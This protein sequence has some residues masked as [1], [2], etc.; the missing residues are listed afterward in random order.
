[1]K[2]G[3][4]N[5]LLDITVRDPADFSVQADEIT[6]CLAIRAN[7]VNPWVLPRLDFSLS[8]YS[9]KPQAIVVDFGSEPEYAEQIRQTCERHQAKLIYVNDKDT[10][11]LAKARNIAGRAVTT[12]FL[13]FSDLDYVYDSDFFGKIARTATQ[14]RM[15]KFTRRM[16]PMPIYHLGKSCTRHFEEL[17][18]TREKD[19]LLGDLSFA[20]I[21]TGFG[22]SFDFVAPYS[23][24]F[25]MHREFFDLSG[26]YCDDFRGHGS[27]DFEY[28]IRLAKL[29]TNLPMAGALE[30]DFYGPLKPSFFGSRD[31]LGFRRY[32]EMFTA[33]AEMLGLKTFHMWHDKPTG[34]NYWTAQNDWK[35]TRFNEILGKYQNSPKNILMADYHPRSKKAL[36]LFSDQKQWGYFLPLRLYG[37]GLEACTDLDNGEQT[38]ELLQRL[39][40]KKFDRICIFN[41][42]M[43]SHVKFRSV[44]EMAK[45]LG[46]PLT[47]IERGGL[48]GSLYY[49]DEVAYGDPDYKSVEDILATRQPVDLPGI[50]RFRD[51]LRLGATA[52]EQMEP[53]AD[54]EKKLIWQRYDSRKKVFIPLQLGDDMAVN[55]FVG[56]N[57]SYASF[58]AEIGPV[59]EKNPDVLFIVKRHPLNKKKSALELENIQFAEESAN[60][61]ALIDVADLVVTY[62]SGVGLLSIL[63]EKPT[64]NV[65]TSYYTG[66]AGLSNKAESLESAVQAYSSSAY[67][68]PGE[69]TVLAYLDWLVYDKYSWFTA[70]NVIR[71]FSERKSHAYDDISVESIVLNGHRKN[72]GRGGSEFDFS[73]T[74]YLAFRNQASPYLPP[75]KSSA[76]APAPIAAPAV[77]AARAAPAARPPEESSKPMPGQVAQEKNK[78]ALSKTL[79]EL[80]LSSRKLNK[81]KENPE[82][83]FDDS[84]SRL[85]RLFEKSYLP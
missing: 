57:R 6:L 24:A 62:N 77:P 13:I 55:H 9:P 31:Y 3:V 18:T 43:K 85:I 20:A 42:Y 74:S 58:E 12:D 44:V 83:F 76:P 49:A 50:R 70:R 78:K 1:M 11:A 38:V 16:L 53:Y 84:N 23:N 47:V 79:F 7:E 56:E 39:E 30:K 14:L 60:I 32:L 5:L 40:Q 52:L 25:L 21:G 48:P 69:Q 72:V 65:G 4:K 73:W 81:L 33:P 63:H 19:Q 10:F 2:Y 75:K 54:T 27:E 51:A 66:S 36:C 64:F 80:F 8:F 28:L 37:Y 45:R 29:S 35:R 15:R 71:E 34:E 41:P 17:E 82:R 61:H 22:E 68:L 26:G 67:H 46:I 59:A